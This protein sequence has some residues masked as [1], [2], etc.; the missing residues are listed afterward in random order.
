MRR[1]YQKDGAIQIAVGIVAINAKLPGWFQ[2]NN[3]LVK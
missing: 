3:S 1:G 2:L